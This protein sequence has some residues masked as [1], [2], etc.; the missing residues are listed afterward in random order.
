MG[1]LSRGLKMLARAL[2]MAAILGG[3]PAM[4]QNVEVAPGV[5][6]NVVEAGE[7]TGAPTLVLVPGWSMASEV[8]RAQIDHFSRDRRV[9]AIDPRSQ[10]E[11]TKTGYG[12]TPAVR[13]R[14]LHAVLEAKGV[15]RPVL[16]GWS[17][18]VQDIAAYV[19]QYGTDDLAGLVL[20]DSAI[21]GGA[22]SMTPANAEANTVTFVRMAIYQQYQ[23][24]YV[25]GFLD[26]IITQPQPQERLDRLAADAMK[27]PPAIGV[28]IMIADLFGD[29]HSAAADKIR[30]PTLVIASDSSPELER[31]RELAARIPGARFEIVADAGHALFVDQPE[32]FNALLTE[33]LAALPV[34]EA[35]D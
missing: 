30:R 1:G 27:I 24:E 25:Q 31:Q 14:D 7:D 13:A 11:S 8:W 33:F 29:D 17:Q 4:A 2:V 34:E 15:R 35:N 26:A 9:I 28:A 16:V 22:R 3:G 19:A 12:N 18:G 6:L 32:R 10:G 23:A 20:V 21:A 5:M